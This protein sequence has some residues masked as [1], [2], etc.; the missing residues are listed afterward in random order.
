MKYLKYYNESEASPSKKAV[1]ICNLGTPDQPTPSALRKYLKQFLSDTRVV[2]LNKYLWKFI[3]YFFILVFRPK[4][5][6]ALYKEIWRKNGSPLLLYSLKQKEKLQHFFNKRS[7]EDVIVE[8]AMSYGNP[9]ISD[10]LQDLQNKNVGEL[11]ILPL[12]PQYSSATS[13]SVFDDI[14]R[15][16]MKQRYIPKIH[17][18]N[19]Y[20]KEDLYLM[21]IANLINKKILLY[22]EPD[23]ILFSYHGTPCSFRDQGDPYYYSCLETT[24]GILQYLNFPAKRVL[25]TF[26]SRFGREPWLQPYTDKKLVELAKSGECRK[27]FVV[28]PGFSSDCLETMEEISQEARDL[29]LDNGG[30]DF[31]YIHALNNLKE[32]IELLYSI[33]VKSFNSVDFKENELYDTDLC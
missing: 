15:F 28:C 20:H 22:K 19:S 14:S 33:S 8:L 25:S 26:Q 7:H 31:H 12:Y 17:F 11:V 30:K 3:L 9:S 13:A 24:S 27:I 10:V 32:H 5:S 23:L 4:K 1:L 2:N 6:A 18:I 16:F 29:F 21:A